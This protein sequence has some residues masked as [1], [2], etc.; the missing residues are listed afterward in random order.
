MKGVVF[1]ASLI[2][3]VLGIDLVAIFPGWWVLVGD[4]PLFVGLSVFSAMV[5]N[6]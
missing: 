5:K 6:S 2:L 3:I 1:A 4:V